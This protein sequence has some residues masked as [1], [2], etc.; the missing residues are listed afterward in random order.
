MKVLY[1]QHDQFLA[2]KLQGYL[3]ELYEWCWLHKEHQPPCQ[4]LMLQIAPSPS[5]VLSLFLILCLSSCD[6]SGAHETVQTV[7][8][9]VLM[10]LQRTVCLS[11]LF[12]ISHKHIRSI[13]VLNKWLS[14]GSFLFELP[15]HWQWVQGFCRSS[16]SHGD[17][18]DAVSCPG[19]CTLG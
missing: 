9:W 15:V 12:Q 8:H 16:H 2:C 18:S 3:V 4:E 17:Y 7:S 11:I 1:G 6:L 13:S 14:L 19:I 5:I 10:F